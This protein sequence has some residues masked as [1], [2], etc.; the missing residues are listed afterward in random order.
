MKNLLLLLL[1]IS[2]VLFACQQ[3]GTKLSFDAKAGSQLEKDT[4]QIMDYLTKNNLSAE[5]TESGLFYIVEKEGEGEHPELTSRVTVHYTGTL[6]NDQKFDSSVDR[7]TPATFP[8]GGVI[9]GWQEGLQLMKPGAKYKFLI[10]SELGYGSRN[11]AGG[12][13][14][15][16][17]PLIFDVELIKF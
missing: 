2:V 3:A 16:N 1:L 7:G 14:P 13:I 12:K 4:S 15:P 8:L 10:P 6:L 11:A 9:K 5:T 17:S